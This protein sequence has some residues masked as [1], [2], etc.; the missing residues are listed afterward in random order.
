VNTPGLQAPRADL[1]AALQDGKLLFQRG[2]LDEAQTKFQDVLQTVPD[3]QAALYY[4]NLIKQERTKDPDISDSSNL[5]TRTFQLDPNTF[6]LNLQRASRV[7]PP[8]LD[9]VA[10]LDGRRYV[11][12]TSPESEIQASVVNFF[13]AIGVDFSP[14]KT[15]SFDNAHC[16]LTVHASADDLDIIEAAIHTLSTAPPQ[17]NI[18]ARFVELRPESDWPQKFDWYPKAPLTNGFFS[19]MLTTSQFKS[20]LQKID[21]RH[22]ADLLNEGQVTTLTGRQAQFAD[23]DVQSIPGNTMINDTNDATASQNKG[24]ETDPLGHTVDVVPSVSD[25]ASTIRVNTIV[26]ITEF[27]GYDSPGMP[28]YGEPPIL[29]QPHSRV[30]QFTNSC[31]VPDGVTIVLGGPGAQYGSSTSKNAPGV[32]ATGPNSTQTNTLLIF[33]TPTVIDKAGNRLYDVAHS[34]DYYDTPLVY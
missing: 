30:L 26:T 23:V 18:K 16:A 22:G 34:K 17:V 29:S 13:H 11:R 25:D 5:D 32:L 27:T 3:N 7:F 24:A 8:V 19:A 20:V 4:L 1:D 14:P 2:K 12:A 6:Y 15:L 9:A 21:K 10:I 31:T 28:L 33:I